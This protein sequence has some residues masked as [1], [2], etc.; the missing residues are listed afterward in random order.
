MGCDYYIDVFLKIEHSDGISYLEL[1]H[2]HGYFCECHMGIYE[3]HEDEEP[4][5]EC[6][7][8]KYLH[9]RMEEFMMKPRPDLI[10]YS[11]KQYKSDFL[12]EKYEPLILEKIEGNPKD[13]IRYSDTGKLNKLD[14][15]ITVTKFEIRY[16]RFSPSKLVVESL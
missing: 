9:K 5:W 16:E 8:A 15:I 4:Y 6:E 13:H 3:E 14:D 12:R 1:D 10:I 11:N 2:I 7:E